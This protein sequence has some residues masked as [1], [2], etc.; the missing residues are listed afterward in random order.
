MTTVVTHVQLDMFVHGAQPILL[1][2]HQGAMATAPRLSY[3]RN[4]ILALQAH[5]TTCSP[6]EPVSLVVALPC[7]HKV[8]SLTSTYYNSVINIH[9][10]AYKS[11]YVKSTT[12]YANLLWCFL[13]RCILMHVHRQKPGIPTL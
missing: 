2:A 6:K 5:S 9:S 7:H 10:I 13:S 11:C 4:A 3:L 8:S 1:H 12:L